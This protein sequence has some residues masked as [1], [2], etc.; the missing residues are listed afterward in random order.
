MES[1]LRV[2]LGILAAGSA[3]VSFFAPELI[4]LEATLPV[5]IGMVVVGLWL[6]SGVAKDQSNLVLRLIIGG[7]FVYAAYDKIIHPDQFARIIYNYH[8]VPGQIINVFALLLPW[9]E[10]ISGILVIVGYWHKSGTLIIGGLLVMFI[11]ALSIALAKGVN[12]EC[13]CFSTT[14]KAKGPIKDL[15]FRDVLS[16]MACGIILWTRRSWLAIERQSAHP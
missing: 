12:I 10:M 9:V 16:L 6:V 4:P 3:V 7:M 14:S 8:Q 15:I 11:V 13:G 2:I 5:K 1:T